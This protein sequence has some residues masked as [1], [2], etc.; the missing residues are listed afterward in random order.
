MLHEELQ[1]QRLEHASPWE[2]QEFQRVCSAHGFWSP[3]EIV[4]H[5]KTLLRFGM[6][7]PKMHHPLAVVALGSLE[8][9]L[10]ASSRRGQS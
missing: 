3:L 9:E 2:V 10:G 6:N 1:Q 4:P 8:T 5:P 7:L